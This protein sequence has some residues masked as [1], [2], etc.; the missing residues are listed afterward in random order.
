MEGKGPHLE[1]TPF[2][3][4][5]QLQLLSSPQLSVPICKGLVVTSRALVLP[6]SSSARIEEENV[7]CSDS[8]EP[9]V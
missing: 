7:S 5:G 1:V 9:A 8:A 2:I 6:H 3:P 4:R